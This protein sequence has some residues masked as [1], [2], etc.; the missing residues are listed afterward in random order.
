MGLVGR[1]YKHLHKHP[2]N[3]FHPEP[4]LNR[5]KHVFYS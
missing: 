5:E 3:A 4:G 1:L 2:N